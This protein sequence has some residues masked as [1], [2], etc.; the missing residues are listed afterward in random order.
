MAPSS[1]SVSDILAALRSA[2][3][4]AE[5]G[6]A[7]VLRQTRAAHDQVLEEIHNAQDQALGN[8]VRVMREVNRARFEIHNCGIDEDEDGDEDGNSDGEDGDA[9]GVEYVD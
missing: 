1:Q 8:Y 3:A 9:S 5:K 6:Y 2:E 4:S 7:Q